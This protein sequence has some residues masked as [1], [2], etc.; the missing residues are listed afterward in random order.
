[1]LGQRFLEVRGMM[2]GFAD[3]WRRFVASVERPAY[4]DPAFGLLA[5]LVRKTGSGKFAPGEFVR[6]C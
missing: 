4:P 5:R 2:L 6:C 3:A 1:M